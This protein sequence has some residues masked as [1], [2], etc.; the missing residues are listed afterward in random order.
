MPSEPLKSWVLSRLLEALYCA[1]L[2]F[3]PIQPFLCPSTLSLYNF[4][5]NDDLADVRTLPAY[6]V[7]GGVIESDT[8]DEQYL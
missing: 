4:F 7:H 6:D 8:I 3:P 1:F 5:V 2:G